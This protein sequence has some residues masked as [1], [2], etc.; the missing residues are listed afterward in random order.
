MRNSSLVGSI[1]FLSAAIQVLS[2]VPLYAQA[3]LDESSHGTM[4]GKSGSLPLVLQVKANRQSYIVRQQRFVAEGS[5]SVSFDGGLLEADRIEFNSYF[6]TLFAEGNVRFRRGSQYLQASSFRYNLVHNSGELKDV[7]GVFELTSDPLRLQ[8]TSGVWDRRKRPAIN[9][10]GIPTNTMPTKQSMACPLTLP[11]VPDWHPHPWAITVWGGQMIDA[12]FGD[13]F[14][15]NGRM[16]P[17]YLLGISMQRRLWRIGPLAFGLEANFFGHYANKQAGGPFNQKV[18]NADILTQSFAESIAGIF[19]RLWLRPWLSLG[20]VEGVSYYS[21]PSSYE[22]TYR[23]A[24]AQLLNY[25]G[26][27]LEAVISQR[28]SVVGRVHHRSG[29]FKTYSGVEEGSNAY[30]LG[31]RYRWGQDSSSPNQL[32]PLTSPLGC[33]NLGQNN[34]EYHLDLGKKPNTIKLNDGNSQVS[35]VRS[36]PDLSRTEKSSLSPVEQRTLREQIIANAEQRIDNIRLQQHQTI[37]QQFGI[38]SIIVNNNV[39][40]RNFYSGIELQQFNNRRFITGKISRWRVQAA[41]IKI[42]PESWYSDYVVLTNDPYTPA[43]THIEAKNVMIS[44]D[45]RGNTTLRSKYNRLIVEQFSIPISRTVQNYQKEDISSR[46][47]AGISNKD[48]GGFY[49]GRNLKSLRFGDSYVLK[50]QPQL[51]VQRGVST[52]QKNNLFGLEAKL[53]GKALNWQVKANAGVSALNPSKFPNGNRF[54]AELRK[55]TTLPW[56]G[57]TKTRLFGAYRHRVWNGS[58]GKALVHSSYGTSIEQR[59]DWKWGKFTSNYVWR[60]GIGNYQAESFINKKFRSFWRANALTSVNSSLSVWEGQPALFTPINAYRYSPVTIVP[61]LIIWTNMNTQL[62]AYSNNRWQAAVRFS[63]GPMLTLGT[64]SRPFLDYTQLSVISSKTLKQGSS[65][66]KFDQTI[67][68]ETVDI[69]LT[70]QIIGPLLVSASASLN[71]DVASALYGDIISSSIGLNWQQ[72]SY[73]LSLY[74][75]LYKGIAGLRFQLSNFNFTGTGLPFIP[76]VLN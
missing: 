25:L 70:Q 34:W 40:T 32:A 8:N 67:D 2:P 19:G 49:V 63:A 27:E 9:S 73:N 76:Y 24:Y 1:A 54:L 13:V 31:V 72:R 52:A 22:R 33:S 55:D 12:N 61:G 11:S 57:E 47:I 7:Y 41:K 74:Y 20:V 44:R 29:A 35:H 21:N 36:F 71:I 60:A 17:E 15:L 48:Q 62:A 6:N 28:L 18:P 50:L 23:R 66:F 5:V 10:W 46:W 53:T 38:T 30:L 42:T 58:L 65:P 3:A 69:N 56:I 43:Q 59:G 64:F 75:D 4:L 14:L 51:L 16:R 26:I 45:K 37:E 68:L 39:G